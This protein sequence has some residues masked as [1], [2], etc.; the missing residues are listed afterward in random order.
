MAPFAFNT[1]EIEYSQMVLFLNQL[2]LFGVKVYKKQTDNL[3]DV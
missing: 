2:L 3:P 1:Y